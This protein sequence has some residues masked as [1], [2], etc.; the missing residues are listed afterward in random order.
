MHMGTA[1]WHPKWWTKDQHESHWE[2]VKEALRRDWE[3][4][5]VD[6]KGYGSGLDQEIDDTVKQAVGKEPI[7]P[8][9]APNVHHPQ[10]VTKPVWNDV[11]EPIKYGVGARD[12]YGTK[13]D[14]KLEGTLKTEWESVKDG[15]HRA[16][17][18]VRHFV[19]HGYDRS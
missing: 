10:S 18:E 11:E 3:Q 1:A 9:N 15:S 2:R 5:K 14:D 13:W 4:T 12:Q 19:R 8:G 7:P 6:L 17:G 16:W